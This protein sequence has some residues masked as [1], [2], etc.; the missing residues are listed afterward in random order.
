L[1]K[2][3]Q[4]NLRIRLSR[5][6]DETITRTLIHKAEYPERY[7][8]ADADLGIVV[9]NIAVGQV[10]DLAESLALASHLEDPFSIDLKVP[11]P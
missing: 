8:V 9:H 2:F 7:P 3:A 1:S 4:S 10:L 5:T 11:D 6:L